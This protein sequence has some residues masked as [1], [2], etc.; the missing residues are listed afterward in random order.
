MRYKVLIAGKNNSVIDDFFTQMSDYFEVMTTSVRYTDMIRHL[1]YFNPDIFVYC[2]YNEPVDVYSQ[3]V[4]V[5]FRLSK[6]RIPFVLIGLREECDEFERTAV[7]VSDLTLCKPLTAEN[8]LT[9]I[10]KF[11]EKRQSAAQPEE[12]LESFV[13][14]EPVLLEEPEPE[15]EKGLDAEL[16]FE[17]VMSGRKHI[18]VVDDSPLMLKT[19]KENLKADYDVATAVSGKVA[20]KFLEHRK[21]D[22]ILLDY[23]MPE[24][25]GPVVLEK[26]RK[27]KFTKDIPVIFLTGVTD[28]GKIK[29]ALVLKPQ[30]YL[31]K[32]IDRTKLIDAIQSVI[33]E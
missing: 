3:M 17:N 16:S 18:L 28:S 9:Q 21:T 27:D 12:D 5:N 23:E 30:G 13:Q 11:M 22:L 32:P 8:A 20:L 31:L 15:P 24:E 1:Q 29:E 25:S 33:G 7:G 10:L 14:E 2:I 4:N 19:L 26:L 6:S